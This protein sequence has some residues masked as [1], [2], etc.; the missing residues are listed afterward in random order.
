MYRM[1]PVYAFAAIALLVVGLVGQG[2]EMR[3]ISRSARDGAP[4]AFLDRRNIKWYV[5]IGAGIILWY[6][7]GG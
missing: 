7:G 3:R 1:E 2:F 5:I 6:M 4:N